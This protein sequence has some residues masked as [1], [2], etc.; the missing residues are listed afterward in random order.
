MRLHSSIVRPAELTRNPKSH[1][2]RENSEISGRNS[3]S[4][5]SLAKRNRMSRSEKGNNIR[6]PYPPSASKLSPSFDESCSFSASLNTCCK[7]RSASS[8][9]ASSVVFAP[10]PCSKFL[11]MRARSS[12]HCAPRTAS[13][14]AGPA[15]GLVRWFPGGRPG[16]AAEVTDSK[17]A[18]PALLVA[19]PDGFVHP[20]KEYL[21]VANLSCLGCLQNRIHPHVHKLV[22]QYQFQF[23][24]RQEIYRVLASAVHLCM[25]L[26]PAVSAHFRHGHSFDSRFAQRV[27]HGLKP[28][29]LNDGFHFHHE[30]FAPAPF[31]PVGGMPHLACEIIRASPQ[32]PL[33]KNLSPA[34]IFLMRPRKSPPS[35]RIPYALALH[36]A[37]ELVRRPGRLRYPHAVAYG[38]SQANCAFQRNTVPLRNINWLHSIPR[39]YCCADSF[40]GSFVVRH[41]RPTSRLFGQIAV[42][43]NQNAFC[44]ANRRPVQQNSEMRRQSHPPRMRVTL[45]V[46]KQQ[47]RHALQFRKRRQ[48]RG[49]FAETQKSWYIRESQ[50]QNRR[51]AGNLDHFWETEHHHTANR[52]IRL[53]QCGPSRSLLQRL[54]SAQSKCRVQPRHRSDVTQPVFT[55]P[56]RP[57]PFLNL[58]RRGRRDVPLMQL[59]QSH[60]SVSRPPHRIMPCGAGAASSS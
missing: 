39:S 25:A 19:N 48:Q 2:V 9:S 12:S 54:R 31:S 16:R 28:R 1:I 29:R 57:Q 32:A 18:F 38:Q 21:T 60:L 53:A 23:N 55:F 3:S 13:G 20:C 59:R 7:L 35:L 56:F 45:P 8:H 43:S 50:R 30:R 47:I 51:R 15:I 49:Y 44:A 46:A 5:F 6:R 27:L 11:R 41:R 26:L 40:N 10:A 33:S 36:F 22:R 24:F 42:G 4:V 14:V 52:A 37:Y 34:S 58:P 17:R